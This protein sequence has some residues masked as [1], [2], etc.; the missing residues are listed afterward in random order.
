MQERHLLFI[1]HSQLKIPSLQHQ[2][3]HYRQQQWGTLYLG[4]QHL[5]MFL[6]QL[7][8]NLL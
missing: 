1:S 6:P 7:H 3:Q 5:V 8:S 4:Q 2:A